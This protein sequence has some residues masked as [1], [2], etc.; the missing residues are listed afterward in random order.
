[1]PNPVDLVSSREDGDGTNGSFMD[2][3]AGIDGS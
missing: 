3:G 2:M 1:V